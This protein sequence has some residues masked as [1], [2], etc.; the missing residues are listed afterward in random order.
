[1]DIL[2]SELEKLNELGEMRKGLNSYLVFNYNSCE[3]MGF[4]NSN[5]FGGKI[6]F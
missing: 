2:V 4:L 5:I 3:V 6:T 1:V